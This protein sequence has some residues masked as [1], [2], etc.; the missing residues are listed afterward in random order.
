M[1]DAAIIVC[2][3][4]VMFLDRT[5]AGPREPYPSTSSKSGHAAS[6]CC[7]GQTKSK[8]D[9]SVHVVTTLK[10]LFSFS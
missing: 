4:A 1:K 5:K 3:V 7:D 6:L 2:F 9:T 8:N 10:K